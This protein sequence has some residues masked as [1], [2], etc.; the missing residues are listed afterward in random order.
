MHS[1]HVYIIVLYIS[2]I[3]WV[4]L[5]KGDL[6]EWIQTTDRT[7][8]LVVFLGAVLIAIVPILPFGVVGGILGAKY[9]FAGG[10]LLSLATSSFASVIMYYL[11]RYLFKAQ[12][13]RYLQKSNRMQNWDK[14]VRKHMFWSILIA[15]IIPIMPS[16]FIN[17]YA[18]VFNLPVKSFLLAT[19]IGKIPPM[20]VFAYV[21][22]NVS[23][24]TQQWLSISGIYLLFLGAVYLIYRFYDRRSAA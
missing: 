12:G 17:C 20:L 19:V 3:G 8:L 18:G 13:M 22:D 1:K 24:G 6:I 16:V 15:R 7:P 9:G 11:F 23:S 21:G 5:N 10:G 4:Y 2:I 14:V